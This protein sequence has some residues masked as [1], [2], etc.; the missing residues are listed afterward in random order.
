MG[1]FRGEDTGSLAYV[2]WEQTSAAIS[3]WR[4]AGTQPLLPLGNAPLERQVLDEGFEP[5]F[6]T[7]VELAH[8]FSDLLQIQ[9]G[10]SA[11][12]QAF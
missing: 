2:E 12:T 10:Q 1:E 11:L 3:R 9:T 5:D 8:D 4:A 7:Q 6:A